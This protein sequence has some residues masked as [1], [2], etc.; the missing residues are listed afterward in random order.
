M[1]RH[2]HPQYTKRIDSGCNIACH[3][4]TSGKDMEVS[5]L[6]KAKAPLCAQ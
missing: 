6:T 1:I 2:G 5:S 3:L 4:P